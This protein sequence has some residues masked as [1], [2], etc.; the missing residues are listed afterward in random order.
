MSEPALRG[1]LVERSGVEIDSA[2]DDDPEPRSC[3]SIR[4][5]AQR[6][7]MVRGVASRPAESR[8]STC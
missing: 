3:R 1:N 5:R 6:V 8:R 7:Y 2:D 4:E